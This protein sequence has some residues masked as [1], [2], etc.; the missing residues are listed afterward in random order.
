MRWNQYWKEIPTHELRWKDFSICNVLK[1]SL[2]HQ[3]FA[4]SVIS[5]KAEQWSSLHFKRVKSS[6]STNFLQK[7]IS[8]DEGHNY[9]LQSTSISF[10]LRPYFI[11][12]INHKLGTLHMIILSHIKQHSQRSFSRNSLTAYVWCFIKYFQFVTFHY[13]LM[14]CN[15]MNSLYF[16]YIE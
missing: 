8:K 6:I 3:C 1:A 15:F 12:Q 10:S 11:T 5:I 9:L 13:N 2:F 7:C 4:V 14:G 16:N